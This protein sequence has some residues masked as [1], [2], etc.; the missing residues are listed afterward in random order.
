MYAETD[1]QKVTKLKKEILP[2]FIE[3][4]QIKSVYGFYGG[5]YS[6]TGGFL[7]IIDYIDMSLTTGNA[8]DRG[9]TLVSVRSAAGIAA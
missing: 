8:S 3:M 2:E 5:G 4:S 9:D 1:I 7:D 6:N